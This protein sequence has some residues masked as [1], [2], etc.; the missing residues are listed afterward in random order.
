VI[1]RS[2]QK[3]HPD[4]LEGNVNIV[5][6]LF[7]AYFAV[8]LPTSALRSGRQ[9]VAGKL[10]VPRT[11]AYLQTILVQWVWFAWAIYATESNGLRLFQPYHL[12]IGAIV[13]GALALGFKLA[14]LRVIR[15]DKLPDGTS[16]SSKLVPRSH[17]EWALYTAMAVTGGIVEET[18]YR[19]ALF[20][21]VGALIGGWW[22][23]ALSSAACFGGVHLTQ[24]KRAAVYAG[25]FGLVN[26]VVVYAT[27][28]LYV[29]M[30]GHMMYDLIA[31]GV[32]IRRYPQTA[33]A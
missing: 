24:G 2:I 13:I 28:T 16:A 19:G 4:G 17:Y 26:Q 5:G 31:A 3:R 12:T 30:V 33:V 23:P 14:A 22:L 15:V 29:A 1:P 6:S 20:S 10:P 25:V 18:V 8:L 9:M 21:M 27:G 32:I 7:L 11:R